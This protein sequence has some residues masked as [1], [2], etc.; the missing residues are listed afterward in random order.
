MDTDKGRFIDMRVRMGEFTSRSPVYFLKQVKE[1]KGQ[2]VKCGDSRQQKR[3]VFVA[4][5]SVLTGKQDF[6][7]IMKVYL[8]L[9]ATKI[10]QSQ[11]TQLG[12]FLQQSFT[13]MCLDMDQTEIICNQGTWVQSLVREI[14]SHL[15]WSN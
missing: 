2:V 10:C 15:L 12:H 7:A 11:T 4:K 5:E 1:N 3:A 6:L 8:R 14:R 13:F 9:K